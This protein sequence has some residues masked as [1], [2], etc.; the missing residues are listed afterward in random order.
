MDYFFYS[1]ACVFESPHRENR[2]KNI[3]KKYRLNLE[4]IEKIRD[5][6]DVTLRIYREYLILFRRI[7]YCFPGR[8]LS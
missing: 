8:D 1:L 5:K 2:E 6:G 3:D 7:L 4:I